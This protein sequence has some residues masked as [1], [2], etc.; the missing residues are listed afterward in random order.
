MEQNMIKL[1]GVRPSNYFG[2]AKTV[3]LEKGIEFEEVTTPPSQEDSFLQK[4][5]MG[6]MPAIEV[7]D[8]YISESM[9]IA[10]WAERVQPTPA[11]LPDDPIAAAKAMELSCHLKLDVELVAR[12]VLPAAF[13]GDTASQET[14]DSTDQD[15]DRG[16]KAVARIFKGQPYAAGD[17]FT[18]ADLYTYFTFSLACPI[19]QKIYDRDLLEGYPQIAGVMALLSE[20]ESIQRVEADKA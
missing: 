5:P 17:T 4:S 9:A 10:L 7:D 11:L 13:F 19:V 2:L 16:M 1:Y 8:S 20:R 15:L 3:L 14:L 12:R 6:K 18:L